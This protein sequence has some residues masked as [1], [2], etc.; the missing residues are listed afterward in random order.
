ML[1]GGVGGFAGR[2]PFAWLTGAYV[3]TGQE[4]TFLTCTTAQ[5]VPA[6]TTDITHLPTRCTGSQPAPPLPT[7]NYVVPDFRFQQAIKYVL[8]M[9]HDFGGGL[10]TSLDVIHTRTRNS[11]VV[12]DVNLVER[13][14]NAE[15]RMMYGASNT[16]S[17]H[18]TRLD[19]TSFGPVFRYENRTADRSTAVTATLEKRWSSGGELDVGYNW[20]RT[21]DVMSLSGNTAPAHVH[22]QSHRRHDR[23]AR[24][25]PLGARYSPQP[26]RDGHRPRAIRN[27]RV[28]FLPRPV[29]DPVCLRD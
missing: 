8:G 14:V 16:A 28:V 22:E 21:E 15:G 13:G 3:N 25:A 17:I 27:H 10:T 5:G 24:A 23:Q 2:P 11:L 19:S 9:D 1:R 26:R 20:S 12:G 29:G 4:Q 7:I 18:S 6:P